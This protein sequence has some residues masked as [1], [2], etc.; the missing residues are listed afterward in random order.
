MKRFEVS[1]NIKITIDAENEE[2]AAQKVRMFF[3]DSESEL[4][5]NQIYTYFHVSKINKVKKLKF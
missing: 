4:T 3:S 5:A 2:Q 1:T